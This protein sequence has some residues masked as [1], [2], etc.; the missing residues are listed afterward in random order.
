MG[1]SSPD[2]T[3]WHSYRKL[4]PYLVGLL[5]AVTFKFPFQLSV[6]DSS[7]FYKHVKLLILDESHRLVVVAGTPSN[8]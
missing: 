7:H 3:T 8:K 5:T 1:S 2:D 6:K 4:N